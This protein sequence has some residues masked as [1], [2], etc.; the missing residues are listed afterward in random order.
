QLE[1]AAARRPARDRVMASVEQRRLR[2]A[3][4]VAKAGTGTRK[5]ETS[6]GGGHRRPRKTQAERSAETQLRIMEAAVRLIR[7]RGYA[8]FRTAEVARIAGVSRGAMLHHYPTKDDL[9]YATLQHVYDKSLARTMRQVTRPRADEDV[10]EGIIEDAKAF[11]FQDD[12]FIGLDIGMAT[13][14]DAFRERTRQMAKESRLP[15]EKAWYDVLVASGIPPQVAEDILWL[16]LSIV[17]GFAVRMLWQ[18]EP[19]RFERLFGIW[20][21]MAGAYIASHLPA[22][23]AAAG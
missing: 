14:D 16:T 20:R 2:A 19:D 15:A 10:L 5:S 11:F 23:A 13:P 8:N 9:V 7:N 1:P 21:E 6:R 12:F 17:R 3:A 4:P 22:K 18:D